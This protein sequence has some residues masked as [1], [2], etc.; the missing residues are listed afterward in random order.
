[1]KED[2]DDD[3]IQLDEVM[4]PEVQEQQE[5]PSEEALSQAQ[6]AEITLDEMMDL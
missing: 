6:D 3:Q 4:A 2:N 1:M 5:S